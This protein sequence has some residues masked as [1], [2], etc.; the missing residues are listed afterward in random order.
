M[1]S[2][3][4]DRTPRNKGNAPAAEQQSA[5]SWVS[6]MRQHFQQTGYYRVEDLDRL[7]GD[8]RQSVE[9]SSSPFLHACATPQPK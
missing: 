8:P 7:L 2:K 5:A 9:I 1:A 3:R 6:G 4:A